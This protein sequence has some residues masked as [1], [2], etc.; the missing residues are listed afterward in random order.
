MIKDK[1]LPL[2]S[3][4]ILHGRFEEG[5]SENNNSENVV[6]Y[7]SPEPKNR[8]IWIGVIAFVIISSGFF[9]YYLINQDEIDSKI[10]QNIPNMSAEQIMIEKY[11]V[12]KINSDHAHAA[13]MIIVDDDRINF[14]LPQFQLSSKYIHFESHNSYLIHKHATG[15]PLEMLFS[16]FG[17]KIIDNCIMLNYEFSDSVEKYCTEKDTLLTVFVNGERYDSDITQYGINHNDRILVS[18]SNKSVSE[19]LKILD[20]LEIFDVPKKIPNG[21]EREVFV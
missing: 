8:W 5:N 18:I 16:S 2:D 11:N 9:S 7:T 13:I 4:A 10:I 21:S 12:G 15:V 14:G 6:E 19:Y 17:M 20:S 1:I 3:D